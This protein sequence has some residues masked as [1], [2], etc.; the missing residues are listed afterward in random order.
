M[1]LKKNIKF[2]LIIFA[3]AFYQS[4]HSAEFA[5][6]KVK[7][8]PNP[9]SPRSDTLTIVPENSTT[10]SGT[11]EYKIYNFNLKEVFSGKVS[12]SA[13]YW[14]GHTADGRAAIPGMY[15]IKIIQT[16]SDYSTGST[17]IK[18]IIK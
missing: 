14:S 3:F 10:F 6:G 16:K 15:I 17:M 7:A 9:F 5:I 13:I 2:L 11:V 12:N 4:I 8:Y 18:L 1:L